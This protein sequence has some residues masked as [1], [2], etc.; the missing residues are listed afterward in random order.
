M[1]RKLLTEEQNRPAG[2]A[3]WFSTHPLT[4]D[5]I[6]STQANIDRIP[7]SQRSRLT[8]DT[9]AFQSFKTRLRNHSPRPRD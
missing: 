9:N 5:R 6:N 4:Q 8:T 3:Q 7:A 1:F 2:V